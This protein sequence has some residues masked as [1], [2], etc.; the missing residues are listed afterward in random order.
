[1][2]T[3]DDRER[4]FEQMFAH[5]EETRFKAIAKR[6][7]LIGLWAADELSLTGEAASRY[8]EGL[9]QSVVASHTDEAIVRRIRADFETGGIA[10]ADD[11]IREKMNEL[12][13][14]A[15]VQVRATA[16]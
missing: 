1:M 12:L 15:L 6:N 7:K 14:V 13:G 10:V 11:Q 9:R 5:E 4:G 8:A 2:T 16:S 3:F